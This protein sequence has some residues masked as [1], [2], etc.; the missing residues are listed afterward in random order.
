ME[1]EILK[2][3]KKAGEISIKIKEFARTLLKEG[4]LLVDIADK[5]EDKIIELGGKPAFPANISINEFA[6]HSIPRFK[7]QTVL[8]KN[9]LVTVDVGIQIDGFIADTAFS[10]SIGK[11]EENEKLIA[12]SEAAL[13][14]ALKL[15]KP[16]TEIRELGKA[17]ANEITSAGFQ[18]IKNLTGHMVG[19]YNLHMGLRIPN[20]D[21]GDDRILE[22][23][24]VLAIEP[25]A[26]SGEGIVVEGKSAEIFKLEKKGVVRTGREILA[27]IIKNYKTLP[28]AKRW[29]VKKFGLLK[30]NLFLKEALAKEILKDYNV[31]REKTG[32]KVSQAEHTVIVAE[33]PIITT[34]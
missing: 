18:P 5:I 15:A 17:I 22:K 14:A 32:K 20:Y 13:N 26:T 19:E 11:S 30:T 24:M 7:E 12:A 10:Y 25:F 34:K 28:F 1:K 27:H 23:D 9:D 3:Y 6:A 31:L 8:T 2:K 33:K 16:D 29:L 21:N 4:A